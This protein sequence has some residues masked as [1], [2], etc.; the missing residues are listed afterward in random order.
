MSMNEEN[1]LLQKWYCVEQMHLPPDCA[2][3][4]IA[5]HWDP[6]RGTVIADSFGPWQAIE[7]EQ[8]ETEAEAIDAAN[9]IM[10]HICKVHNEWLEKLLIKGNG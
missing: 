7:N 6:H 3:Y 9:A 5:G 2:T 1:P 4:I 10:Y 8:F